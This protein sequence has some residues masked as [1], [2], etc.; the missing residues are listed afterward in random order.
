M[1]ITVLGDIMCEPPILKASKKADGAY[2]FSGVFEK[3]RPM[4]DEADYVISNLEF[5]L[6]GEETGY[7]DGFFTFNAPDAYLYA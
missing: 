7:S 5:P 6:A 4:L 2:D 3:V 1:K